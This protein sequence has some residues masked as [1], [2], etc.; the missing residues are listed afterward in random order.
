MKLS[1][2]HASR[3]RAQHLAVLAQRES[4]P[5]RAGVYSQMAAYWRAD[6]KVQEAQERAA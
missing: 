3:L 6:A 4:D 2:A 1:P 5:A